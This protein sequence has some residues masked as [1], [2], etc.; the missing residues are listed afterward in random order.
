MA[1]LLDRHQPL[2][3]IGVGGIGM[4][5]LAGILAERGYAVS[6]SDPRDHA[7]LDRLRRLGVRVF[8][9]QSAA[10]VAAIRSGTSVA[11]QVVISSAVPETNPELVEARRV[12][13]AICHRSDVLAALINSQAS[14]AVAGSHGKTTTSSLV[15]SLLA[16]THHDPTAVIGGIVPAFGSNGRHGQGRLLVAEADESDGSLVKFRASLGVL[17]NV[18]LDHTDH[19]PDL[20]ALIN[21]LQRF[22]GNTEQLLAN[23]DCPILRERFMP[24]HWWSIETAEGVSFAALAREERGDGTVADFYENGVAVGSFELPLPGRHNLSNAV[25]AMAACRLEGVSFAELRQAVAALKTPGRRFDFRGLWEG[26]LVVDDY[27]HHPSEVA[28]TLAMARLMVT[29]GRSS[30]PLPPR[31]LVAVFQPH[32]YS[33]TAQ[34]LEGFA[35][36]L[37][38]ADS[39]LIAPLYAAGETPI[40]GISSAAMA[41]AVRE[42]APLLPVQVAD[43]LEELA[44]QVAIASREGD[45]VLA[46]GAGDVN[47]LWDRLGQR[48]P[49]AVSNTGAADTALAA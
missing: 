26:R 32:R 23:R 11:P 3:F 31:R 18:E 24:A 5:A 44:A 19:Y 28:A 16:A 14:I 35:A 13:L 20:E 39:V 29:S 34:F 15:A 4:S 41:D 37:T 22:A 36:A 8:L 10:T 9:E 7:V 49:G 42:R 45:L 17:T 40:P 1:P 30:L 25:A 27:A 2:H 38:E 6:G 46:M 43:S 12:G 48:R 47:S 33:R 21:T